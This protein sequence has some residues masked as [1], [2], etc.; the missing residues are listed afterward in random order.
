[1]A[2]HLQLLLADT[3]AS[4]FFNLFACVDYNLCSDL[5]RWYFFQ[6]KCTPQYTTLHKKKMLHVLNGRSTNRIIVLLID[7]LVS[8]TA[9]C[10]GVENFLPPSPFNK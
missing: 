5:Q 2:P 8:V 6:D 4:L 7:I 10:F 9:S 3:P 1:M